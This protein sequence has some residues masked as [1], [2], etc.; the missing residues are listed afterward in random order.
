MGWL[1]LRLGR[2]DWLRPPARPSYEGLGKGAAF[3][4]RYGTT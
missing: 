2:T 1:W 4:G 3:W